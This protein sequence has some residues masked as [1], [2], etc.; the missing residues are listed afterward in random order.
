MLCIT[1]STLLTKRS[2][3]DYQQPH[4]KILRDMHKIKYMHMFCLYDLHLIK[5]MY[6]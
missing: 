4:R 5:T 1:L 6:A 3:V 2:T